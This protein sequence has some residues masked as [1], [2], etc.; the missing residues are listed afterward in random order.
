[1][2]QV[3]IAADPITFDIVIKSAYREKYRMPQVSI[4]ADP[5]TFG[6]VTK[7]GLC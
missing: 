6:I 2:P 7:I 4:A 1:M 5:I 3:P